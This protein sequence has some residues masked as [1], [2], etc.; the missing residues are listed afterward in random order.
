MCVNRRFE[1]DLKQVP[2]SVNAYLAQPNFLEILARQ[3]N[4]RI[5]TLEK[6]QSAL[7]SERPTT[8][9]DCVRWARMKFQDMFHNQ[10]A[11]V[12]WRR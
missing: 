4:T 6:I 7:V 8:I 12:G 5:D 10:I 1:G 9:E 2:D 3:S 11:Q